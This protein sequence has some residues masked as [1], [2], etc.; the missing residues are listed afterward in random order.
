MSSSVRPDTSTSSVTQDPHQ[1]YSQDRLNIMSDKHNSHPFR[2]TTTS[3]YI[4]SKFKRGRFN[5]SQSDDPF[6]EDLFGILSRDLSDIC[7][8]LHIAWHEWELGTN[9]LQESL[10]SKL[11]AAVESY[12]NRSKNGDWAFKMETATNYNPD[13]TSRRNIQFNIL[14]WEPQSSQDA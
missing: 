13:M 2:I 3:G 7:R 1:I 11:R 6:A 9:V 12:P 4:K 8:P 10:R 14:Y 5:W